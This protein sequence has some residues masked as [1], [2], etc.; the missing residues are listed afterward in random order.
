MWAGKKVEKQEFKAS[1]QWNGVASVQKRSEFRIRN[2]SG[3]TRAVDMI[4]GR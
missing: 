2:Y 1:N 3:N 4:P